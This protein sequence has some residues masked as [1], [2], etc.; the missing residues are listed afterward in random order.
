METFSIATDPP[1]PS[2]NITSLAP[3]NLYPYALNNLLLTKSQIF[4]LWKK[5]CG[6]DQT[7]IFY[8]KTGNEK[9]ILLMV[10]RNLY[11]RRFMSQTRQT[12]HFARSEKQVQNAR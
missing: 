3:P 11:N 2:T 6:H 10:K 1:R 9:E 7:V 8:V 5:L 12:W 4:I